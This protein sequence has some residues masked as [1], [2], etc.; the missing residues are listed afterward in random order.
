MTVSASE[1]N[2]KSTSLVRSVVPQGHQ[3]LNTTLTG[4]L[5]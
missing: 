1:T 5:P 2:W 4:P 3:S